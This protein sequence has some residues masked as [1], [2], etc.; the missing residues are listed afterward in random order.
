MHSIRLSGDKAVIASLTPAVTAT[1][2]Q[3]FSNPQASAMAA[4]TIS[5]TTVPPDTHVK[6]EP[7]T[8]ATTEQGSQQHEGLREHATGSTAEHDDS[9]ATAKTSTTRPA[10]GQPTVQGAHNEEAVDEGDDDEDSNNGDGDDGAYAAEYRSLLFRVA[11]MEAQEQQ[12]ARQSGFALRMARRETKLMAE[13][14]AQQQ[15]YL[16]AQTSGASCPQASGNAK[17]SNDENAESDT[18]AATAAASARPSA[19]EATAV[20]ATDAR[21]AFLAHRREHAQLQYRRC[22][23]AAGLLRSHA[24]WVHA[25]AQRQERLQAETEQLLRRLHEDAGLANGALPSRAGE[26]QEEHNGVHPSTASPMA[27]QPPDDAWQRQTCGLTTLGGTLSKVHTLFRDPECCTNMSIVATALTEAG[28]QCQSLLQAFQALRETEMQIEADLRQ[29]RLRALEWSLYAAHAQQ[30]REVRDV[31]S[32]VTLAEMRAMGLRKIL[33][34]RRQELQSALALLVLRDAERSASQGDRAATAS[35]SAPVQ[36]LSCLFSPPHEVTPEKMKAVK[37]TCAQREGLRDRLW[38]E[39]LYLK[40][41]ARRDL[42]AAWISQAEAAALASLTGTAGA[43]KGT[44]ALKAVLEDGLRR[45]SYDS[46]ARLVTFLASAPSLEGNGG[47]AAKGDIN[48]R[49]QGADEEGKMQ[50]ENDGPLP[51]SR[52][53]SAA[54]ATPL[55][56]HIQVL[57]FL[58]ALQTRA[59][60]LLSL[61]AE[62][63]KHWQRT[64]DVVAE[65]EIC[66]S[67]TET[68]WCR[69]AELLRRRCTDA[70]AAELLSS[71]T[72]GDDAGVDVACASS[73]LLQEQQL[74]DSLHASQA[75]IVEAI[76]AALAQV[77]HG[78][79]APL[80][81]EKREV[82]LLIRLLQ[83][84]DEAGVSECE[85]SDT[86]SADLLT[87]H[88]TPALERALQ[89][90]KCAE[91]DVRESD[92][93]APS[94]TTGGR[95]PDGG[96]SQVRLPQ[97]P[98]RVDA[99]QR[100]INAVSA[101]W[102][103]RIVAETAEIRSKFT[104][105][106][107][108]LEQYAQYSMAE[109]P[110]L[111]D[112]ALVE[113]KALQERAAERTAR[114]S[115]AAA[116]ASQVQ[117]QRMLLAKIETSERS[118]L[119]AAVQQARLDV[120]ALQTQVAQL[121]ALQD[122]SAAESLH[123]RELGEAEAAAWR[124]LQL[125]NPEQHQ[126]VDGD[127]AGDGELHEDGGSVDVKE[128][129]LDSLLEE[130]AD[131]KAEAGEEE[132]DRQAGEGAVEHRIAF[133]RQDA[134]GSDII[135]GE[136]VAAGGESEERD[137]DASAFSEEG[138]SD[139]GAEEEAP[140]LQ[141][142]EDTAADDDE[143][144]ECMYGASAEVF[145]EEHGDTKGRSGESHTE[146]RVDEGPDITTAAGTDKWA[147]AVPQADVRSE[148]R[149][150]QPHPEKSVRRGAQLQHEHQQQQPSILGEPILAHAEPGQRPPVFESAVSTPFAYHPP[151]PAFP[152]APTSRPVLEDNP[153]YSGFGFEEE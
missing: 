91:E 128:E 122:L 50:D 137:S 109:V 86:R 135:K 130:P 123:R 104:E 95:G 85:R 9:S 136:E 52:S 5:P 45:A 48:G 1:M 141:V 150:R 97:L 90:L 70:G 147:E 35:S 42:G 17:T 84:S 98:R 92:G 26:P 74:L 14:A 65:A 83:L 27:P 144:S 142:G 62:N 76:N 67:S 16:A 69:T 4:S 20:V 119:V 129:V 88:T 22:T 149:R 10:D 44:R 143:E 38:R 145:E 66:S 56:P 25:D 114:N 87:T 139:E 99:V 36:Q 59:N 132:G 33:L 79:T 51:S 12:R 152:A 80:E 140:T 13:V 102:R 61:L 34:R 77:Y 133:A 15:A 110:S 96:L 138:G 43:G 63:A 100:G 94:V 30:A 106:Q 108:R 37:D 71:D 49:S 46:L 89:L 41:C 153:F 53:P 125:D 105:T 39:L 75:T 113:A 111:L 64:Q 31:F 47:A 146:G 60:S 126:T 28:R 54:P 23:D 21:L 134:E 78:L 117:Q 32:P 2:Q 151:P 82:T 24:G 58:E 72:H 112:K 29:R 57:S 7:T 103:D 127:G 18:P 93:A 101:Q 8:A 40:K 118:A 116:L 121:Q 11:E 55:V 131:V 115:R 107:A 3:P 120:A 19:D 6:C 124:T 68:A 73:L 148:K 81:R